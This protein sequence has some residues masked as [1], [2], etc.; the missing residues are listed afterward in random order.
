MV[1]SNAWWGMAPAFRYGCCKVSW[2]WKILWSLSDLAALP[3]FTMLHYGPQIC[4][5]MRI[6]EKI[7]CDLLIIWFLLFL[8]NVIVDAGT[9]HC[10]VYQ[11]VIRKWMW[12]FHGFPV[13]QSWAA[14]LFF[15][16]CSAM[17][18]CQDV[19]S[20][21]SLCPLWRFS[22]KMNFSVFAVTERSLSVAGT[23]HPF[24]WD[25]YCSDIKS[26][27]SSVSFS[28]ASL[29]SWR[30]DP[31]FYLTDPGHFFASHFW[32]Y[33]GCHCEGLIV[34]ERNEWPL[35]LKDPA[36]PPKHSCNLSD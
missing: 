5:Q 23:I 4:W 15:C 2:K 28:N 24:F 10:D 30:I 16:P 22:A 14:E 35:R 25:W 32:G 21:T 33:R 3:R 34:S 12:G 7:C 26:S 31:H 19:P 8:Y 29:I 27:V 11:I 20:D 6:E 1:H 18:Q 17:S 9:L 13:L 36:V